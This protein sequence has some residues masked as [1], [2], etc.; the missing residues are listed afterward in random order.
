MY[1]VAEDVEGAEPSGAPRRAGQPDG[2]AVR[3]G[4]AVRRGAADAGPGAARRESP[5][6][7]SGPAP[8]SPARTPGPRTSSTGTSPRRHPDTRWVA[9]ITYVPTWAGF[10]YVAFVMDLY[11]RRIVGWRVSSTLRSD[12]ALDALEQAI[13]QRRQRRARPGRAGPP[14][15]PRRAVPV[16]PLHR[17]PGRGR[18]HRLRRLQSATPTTTPPPKPSTGSS[19]PSSSDATAPGGPSSTSSSRSSNG[20]TGTTGERLHSW[21]D[22]APPTEYENAYYAAQQPLPGDRRGST[23][24]SP[25]N[26][27]RFQLSGH[28]PTV[29]KSPRRHPPRASGCRQE[30]T[31]RNDVGH[32]WRSS[33][34]EWR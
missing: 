24:D 4:A 34:P 10:V 3:P 19:R 33:S 11:S 23:P 31:Q 27:G 13:W 5:G 16:D 22:D 20:S 32:D 12:L 26:P 30:R 29:P 1:G 28:P 14:L 9:D 8:P 21:C 7:T 2:R 25:L 6:T 17:T 18:H 15:R